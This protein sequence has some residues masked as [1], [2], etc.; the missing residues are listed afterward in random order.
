MRRS[1]IVV[2]IFAVIVAALIGYNQ[3]VRQQPP[4]EVTLAVDPLVEDWVRAAID[5]YNATDPRV[6]NGSVRV[7]YRVESVVGDT[8]AWLGQSGWTAERHPDLW[9]PASSIAVQYYP[10]STFQ[11]IQPS[12]ARTPMVWGGF[13]SRLAAIIRATGKYIFVNR[14]GVK[15]AEETR[16]SLALALKSGRLQVLDDGMLFDRALEAVIGNLR[17]NR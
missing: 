5:Q 12:L 6:Q 2:I 7:Q 13:R 9:I 15:V 4:V 14:S 16:M 1:T 3:Y 10:A 17:T 8:K 11:V